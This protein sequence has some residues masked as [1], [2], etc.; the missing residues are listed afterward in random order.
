MHIAVDA[1]GTVGIECVECNDVFGGIIRL[2]QPF[3]L[4]RFIAFSSGHLCYVVTPISQ[5]SNQP[6][7]SVA[8]FEEYGLWAQQR[9]GCAIVKEKIPISPT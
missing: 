5:S 4:S 3:Q 7:P 1:C 2:F 9:I 8:D 6:V